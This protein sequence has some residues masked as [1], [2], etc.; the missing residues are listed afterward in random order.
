MTPPGVSPTRI[1]LLDSHGVNVRSARLHTAVRG[2]VEDAQKGTAISRE[3]ASHQPIDGNL[4]RA[5][6]DVKV[7][8][9]INCCCV[10]MSC[11]NYHVKASSL[12]ATY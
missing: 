5:G 2:A 8:V 12:R 4:K 11:G 6:G 10:K 1:R 3:R 7:S 9:R